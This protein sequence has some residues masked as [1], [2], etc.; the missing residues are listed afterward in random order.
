MKTILAL[1]LG[2]WIHAGFAIKP[3]KTY[4]MKPDQF[5][6]EYEELKIKTPDQ[7]SLNVW[8]MKT[9]VEKKRNITILIVGSDAG[10][11]G[12]SLPYAVSLLTQGF[13]VITF[14]YRGFGESSDFDFTS[15]HLYQ[16][17]YI[18]DFET[19]VQWI[20][21]DIQPAEIGVLAFSMG[22]FIATVGHNKTPFDFFIGEAFVLSPKATAKRISKVKDKHITLPKRWRKDYRKVWKMKI[23]TMLIT[24]KSDKITKTARSYQ[25][26]QRCPHWKVLIFKGDHLRGAFTMGMDDYVAQIIEHVD[27]VYK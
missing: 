9:T 1:I 4:K 23:P 6:I 5:N 14:D 13:D 27:R 20:K 8:K 25:F 10:N 21:K 16:Q 12:F 26:A 17:E 15:T 2:L 19:I 22:T 18:L 24:S 11:M 7:Y 3:M